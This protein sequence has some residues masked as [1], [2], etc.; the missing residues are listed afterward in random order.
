MLSKQLRQKKKSKKQNKNILNSFKFESI[1]YL[2]KIAKSGPFYRAYVRGA[3]FVI[4]RRRRQRGPNPIRISRGVG[5]TKT[6]IN[7]A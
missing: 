4:F 1:F 6:H 3:N 7:Y 5:C 2:E